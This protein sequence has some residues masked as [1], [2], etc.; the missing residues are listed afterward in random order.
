[1]LRM[2]K[3]SGYTSVVG[4]SDEATRDAETYSSRQ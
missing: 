4:S 3:T 1:M 2:K